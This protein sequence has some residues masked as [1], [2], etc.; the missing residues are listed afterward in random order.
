MGIENF[1]SW[2]DVEKEE[3]RRKA[4]ESERKRKREVTFWGLPEAATWDE[5]NEVS[6]ID[7]IL[8]EKIKRIRGNQETR[9]EKRTLEKFATEEEI[10]GLL[11]NSTIMLRGKTKGLSVDFDWGK[12]DPIRDKNRPDYGKVYS[13]VNLKIKRDGVVI[14][15]GGFSNADPD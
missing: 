3:S 14:Y 15:E 9:N 2:E 12:H 5:I 1:Q 4:E 13:Y 10:L 6:T 11:E 7:A 8:N